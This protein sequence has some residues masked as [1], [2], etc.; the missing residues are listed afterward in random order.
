MD[1]L[2]D[3]GLDIDDQDN[4]SSFLYFILFIACTLSINLK[5]KLLTQDGLTA[6]HK[7]IIGK[8]EAVISHL[9]RKGASPHIRDRVRLIFWL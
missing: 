6:L 3:D 1:K 4:V 7:A 9:L 8:K 2:L 5:L